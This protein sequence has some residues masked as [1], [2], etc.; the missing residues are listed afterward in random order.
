MNSTLFFFLLFA[1]T[2]FAQQTSPLPLNNEQKYT[3]RSIQQKRMALGLLISGGGLMVTAVALPR[4][5][6]VEDGIYCGPGAGILCNEQYKNDNLKSAILL[7]GAAAG[8]S[9]IPFFIASSKNKRKAAK[10]SIGFNSQQVLLPLQKHFVFRRQPA[11]TF[12]MRL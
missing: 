3:Q 2:S 6:L 4:G 7:A 11:L 8:L 1:C 12:T 10:A 9:S 5:A